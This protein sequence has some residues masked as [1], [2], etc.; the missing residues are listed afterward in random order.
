MRHSSE[1]LTDMLSVALSA[2]SM[3]ARLASALNARPSTRRAIVKIADLRRRVDLIGMAILV[4]GGKRVRA[5][6]DLLDA[7][8]EFELTAP[9]DRP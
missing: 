5:A 4:R 9:E 6:E 2:G 1:S 8:S 3:G 7:R